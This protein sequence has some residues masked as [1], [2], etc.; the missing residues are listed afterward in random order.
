MFILLN[1]LGRHA[2]GSLRAGAAAVFMLPV[3]RVGVLK[4]VDG[5]EDALAV[6]GITG[7]HS[8]WRDRAAS[9]MV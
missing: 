5:R 8:A 1:S 7:H 4:A 6:P 2:R 9:A 3:D